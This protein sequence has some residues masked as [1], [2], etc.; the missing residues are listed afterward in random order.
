MK[1]PARLV[2]VAALAA[3]TALPAGTAHAH[4]TDERN[5][6]AREQ[7]LDREQPTYPDPT[8]PAPISQGP[9]AAQQTL[10]RTL[11]REWHTY[12]APIDPASQAAWLGLVRTMG[13]E[14]NAYPAPTG[15]QTIYTQPAEPSGLDTLP[16]VVRLVALIVVL[17]AP[18]MVL[19]LR[20]RTGP[21]EAT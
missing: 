1:T 14:H 5:H 7:T 3:L 11:A 2:A 8:Y 6:R 18:A 4:A 16:A 17:A 9:H 10:A 13:R 20:G 21:R 12:P 19:W 15:Q